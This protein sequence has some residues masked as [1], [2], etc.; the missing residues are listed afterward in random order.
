[1]I[2]VPTERRGKGEEIRQDAQKTLQQ[3][4]GEKPRVMQDGGYQHTGEAG[5]EVGAGAPPGRTP[6]QQAVANPSAELMG[7]AADRAQGGLHPQNLENAY[8]PESLIPCPSQIATYIS[9]AF[10]HWNMLNSF[11][12]LMLGDT[13]FMVRRERWS[14]PRHRGCDFQNLERPSDRTQNHKADLCT[15]G[16]TQVEEACFVRPHRSGHMRYI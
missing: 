8:P 3:D 16:T 2:G 14:T 12:S 1:M 9:H 7:H 13:G 15:H 4:F 6:G 11:L 10:K 5:W